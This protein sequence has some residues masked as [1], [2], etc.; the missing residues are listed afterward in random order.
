[1]AYEQTVQAQDQCF[2]TF[3]DCSMV[4]TGE[5]CDDIRVGDYV[6]PIPA[7]A[8]N[9]QLQ[10]L[11][12]ECA[13]KL[14]SRGKCYTTD[15]GCSTFTVTNCLLSDTDTLYG[16]A[17]SAKYL[18]NNQT[19]AQNACLNDPIFT[20]GSGSGGSAGTGSSGGSAGSG[21]GGSGTGASAGGLGA[22]G[23]GIIN[24]VIGTLGD[25]PQASTK[26]SIFAEFLIIVWRAL[27][28][29][30]ALAVLVMF[31]WGAISWITSGGDNSK[32]Q[33]ARDKITQ[34]VIGLVILVGAFFII[35]YL[36][37]L[38]FGDAF[39]ILNLTIP[40]PTGFKF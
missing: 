4:T 18:F 9:A 24:P 19:D 28:T 27:I 33:Q 38:F 40:T 34:S 14:Q 3:N 5:L 10:T 39:D 37:Q 11:K 16:T 31:L 36:G 35:S 6:F 2:T 1:M 15:D 30:G 29:I 26:G 12:N 21:S 32:V 23:A 8:T 22:V 20:G 13:D 7:G 17:D 25:N